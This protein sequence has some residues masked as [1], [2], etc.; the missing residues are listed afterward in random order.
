MRL[1]RL[2][3]LE[4]EKLISEYKEILDKIAEF[5][6]ILSDPVRLMQ[7]IR[8]EL[9][10]VLEEYGDERRSEIISSKRDLTVADLIT[11][12][13]LVVTISHGGY[14]KTQ[15]VEDY[16]AQRRG[17]RG[18]SATSMKDEDFI[19]KLLVTNSHD[20]ILCFTNKGKVY[21]LRVFEI[22][23]A[24]RGSRGRPMVNILPLD[25]GE[26]VTTFLPVNEYT[27]DHF[28]FM[29]T[30]NGTV[31]KTPLESF[32]RPRTSGLIAL[33]L[34]EGDTLIGAAITDGTKDI[35]LM[36]NSGKMIRFHESNV[37]AMGRTARGVRGIKMAKGFRVVTLMLPE[38]D[39]LLL[40]AS[41]N[42]Y[43]K[44]TRMDEFSV[45]G[46]GGQGVIAMQCSE[47]NGLLVSAVQV[48]EGD[49]LMLIT[50]KGTLVRTRTEE[51]SILG[52]NTQGVRLI[53]LSQEN[54]HLV[55]VERVDEPSPSEIDAALESV[56][57]DV[58]PS[59]DAADTDVEAGAEAPS[60]ESDH[61]S[62]E[63]D[64]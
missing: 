3:G 17:G 26:R 30:A 21:W 60:N 8:E 41:E 52:R 27:E 22:P 59:V 49:E 36:S 58:D 44:R 55:G 61:S 6:S 2:T 39:G 63:T 56:D 25:A 33:G 4:T 54:E 24:S 18:K 37:R 9:E 38:A 45:I 34:D 46:R 48:K 43:G 28:I 29:A 47:R 57:V 13:D 51:I 40:V 19:E 12:E 62:D 31:K 20:T 42:G 5:L 23:Q 7:V 15:P 1:H 10:E 50:D 14:A 16:Q 35:M 64:A 32:A 11:E 53:K